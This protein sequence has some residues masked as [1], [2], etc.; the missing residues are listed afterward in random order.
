LDKRET[1][2]LSC[3]V[4]GPRKHSK[5]ISGQPICFGQSINH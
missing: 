1:N 4:A 5:R 2:W 3:S